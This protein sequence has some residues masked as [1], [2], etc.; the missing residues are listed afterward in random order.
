MQKLYVSFN[1]QSPRCISCSVTVCFKC[2]HLRRKIETKVSRVTEQY[3]T[4]YLDLYSPSV[5]S[6]T[7][8]EETGPVRKTTKHL[9]QEINPSDHFIQPCSSKQTPAQKAVHGCGQ[10]CF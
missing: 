8:T 5:P 2:I 4:L 6:L 10:L 1:G 7:L 3:L 9:R